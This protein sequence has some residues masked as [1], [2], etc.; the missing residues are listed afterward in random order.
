VVIAA[1]AHKL[2]HA[3]RP[4]LI[5]TEGASEVVKKSRHIDR[6]LRERIDHIVTAA[7]EQGQAPG[8]VAGIAHGDAAHVA[9]AGVATLGR[10]PMTR[11][12]L[13]RISSMTKP[14]TAA[15]VL[16]QIEAGVLGL[17][18][19]ADRLLPELA[20]RAVLRAPDGPLADTVPATRSITVRDLLTFTFGFGMQGAMFAAAQP[21]PIVAAAGELNLGTFGPPMP[22]TLPDPDTWMAR[23]GS[24]PLLAQ[25]G[26]RWLYQ[27]GSQVLGVLAA[28][29][30]AKPFADV[31][32]DRLLAP[33]GMHDTGFA[34]ADTARLATAY[35]RSG[36]GWEVLDPPDG[37]WSR[38][39][40][41]AD[42]SGG[43][44][45]TV[46]DLL[47]FGR[48]LLD[49]GT[50]VLA[51]ATVTQM[52]QDQLT[53]AQHAAVWPGF[54]FLGGRGWGYGVSVLEDG[55]YTWDGGL[56]T[57][58]SNIPAQDL[59]VVVLTQRFVDQDGPAPVCDNVLNAA[60]AGV[61][62]QA[63]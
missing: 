46:D 25:P 14:M 2:R 33:L 43:L 50:S 48:M 61:A 21:W 29:A 53:P 38:P 12:T 6:G 8:V 60:R 15:V 52:T 31:M 32:R 27:A 16:A 24:L 36:D 45:S 28:R 59:C 23:L 40:A 51:P 35:Q 54:S 49:G 11:D 41:F 26:E 56:G 18:E 1:G 62:V 13:F 19:P 44:I 5:N 47:T 63:S 22:G 57:A 9:V 7:V 55:R 58:W 30:D 34:A 42:G 3:W 10:S 20:D 17:D 39:P 37:H 4:S